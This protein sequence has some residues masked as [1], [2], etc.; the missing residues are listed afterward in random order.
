ME[1]AIYHGIKE[2]RGSGYIKIS[3]E[4]KNE[5]ICFTI[6]DNGIGIKEEKLIE[7]NEMLKGKNISSSVVGYGIFNVHQKIK[8]T[9]GDE[10]GLE[11]HSIYGKGTTVVL[12]HPI[13]RD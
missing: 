2:K 5:K 6:E 11:Y 13:I 12:W 1:N 10:F 7:I 4:I 3:G 8:L 9:Y